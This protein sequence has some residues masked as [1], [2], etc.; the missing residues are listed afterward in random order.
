VIFARRYDARR[1]EDGPATGAGAGHWG[2]LRRVAG[3]AA[4]RVTVV[5]AAARAG[6]LSR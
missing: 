4:V 1:E 6:A 2:A 3:L 5:R